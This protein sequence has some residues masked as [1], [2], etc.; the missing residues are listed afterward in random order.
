MFEQGRLGRG[1]KRLP[2]DPEGNIQP[3]KMA[4]YA[5]RST[6]VFA[7]SAQPRTRSELLSAMGRTA[8]LAM[9]DIARGCSQLASEKVPLLVKADPPM[10]RIELGS[11]EA[12]LIEFAQC[13]SGP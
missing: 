11:P 1:R 7:V 12:R 9:M 13:D 8:P 4:L 2:P 3:M 6:Q 10:L 5:A